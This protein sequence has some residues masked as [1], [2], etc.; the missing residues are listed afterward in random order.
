MLPPPAEPPPLTAEAAAAKQYNKSVMIAN[1]HRR[2]RARNSLADLPP[3]YLNQPTR[4]CQA[5]ASSS[6]R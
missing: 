4:I 3:L 5:F 6:Q 1:T 2:G